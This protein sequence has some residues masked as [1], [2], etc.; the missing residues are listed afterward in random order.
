L[1]ADMIFYADPSSLITEMGDKSVLITEHRYTNPEGLQEKAG[2]FNVQFITFKNNEAGREVCFWW[3]KACLEWCFDRF[4]DGKFGDQKYLDDWPTRFKSAIHILQHE[5]GG[6]ATWNIQQYKSFHNN[7][8]QLFV[9]SLESGQNFQ[10]IFFH[11]HALK[12]Y[13]DNI[14]FFTPDPLPFDA[15]S[16]FYFPYVKLLLEKRKDLISKY[17]DFE[18][19]GIIKPSP[20]RPLTF[21]DKLY[22]CRTAI[23]N[24]VIQLKPLSAFKTIKELKKDF[25]KHHFYFYKE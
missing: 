22:L 8:G 21:R 11:F 15:K 9:K 17:P 4:E 24:S 13:Q 14:V 12:F 1:D 25:D 2:R 7:K 16:N 5:G 23:V 19:N 20:K 6:L 18:P 3:R 10:A